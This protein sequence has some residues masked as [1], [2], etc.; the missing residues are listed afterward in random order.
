M[1]EAALGAA[2]SKRTYFHAQFRRIAARRGR[3]RAALAVAH[4]LVVVVF[5]V[6]TKSEAY[7]ELGTQHFESRDAARVQRQLVRR[8]ERLGYRVSLQPAA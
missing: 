6:L 5:H 4:A 3:E 2:A 8:L 1:L 7:R